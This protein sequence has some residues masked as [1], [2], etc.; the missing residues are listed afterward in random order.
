MPTPQRRRLLYGPYR[1]PRFRY[2]AVLMDE[3]RGEVVARGLTAARI[4]W[5]VGFRGK[6]RGLVVY[7][8]LAKAVRREAA[9][10]VC[11]W[12]GVTPDTVSR[13][14]KALGVGP[15]TAGTR[16]L[17]QETF[18]RAFTPAVWARVEAARRSPA[19]NAKR[20]AA[21]VGRTQ[22]PEVVEAIR[23]GRTG[24]KHTA[25]AKAK[26]SAAH[27][28]RH[29]AGAAAERKPWTPGQDALLMT[30]PLAKV[31]ASTGRSVKAVRVR[32]QRLRAAA[33]LKTGPSGN[34]SAASATPPPRRRTR[35]TPQ[36]APGRG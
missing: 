8:G 3:I 2:G 27:Q 35:P 22:P 21:R 16:K 30:L 11:H 5:P 15:V 29:A 32:R 7:A 36:P 24:I 14:R 33:R 28:A 26:M 13:W 25:E 19:V 1:T 9:I 6:A 20:A 10:A 12:W 4:P 31:A 17:R 23:R 34:A 18:A